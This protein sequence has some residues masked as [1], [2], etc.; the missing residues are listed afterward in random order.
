MEALGQCRQEVIWTEVRWRWREWKTLSET[1]L[2]NCQE[3]RQKEL[4]GNFES[5]AGKVM[6]HL[7]KGHRRKGRFQE[8]IMSLFCVY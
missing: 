3:L 7:L 8:K 4:S 2:E 1:E 6:N 5:F